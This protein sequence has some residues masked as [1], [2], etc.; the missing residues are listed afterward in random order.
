MKHPPEAPAFSVVVASACGGEMLEECLSSLTGQCA[1]G[2]IIAATN[3]CEVERER[4]GR[5]F[6]GV[7]LLWD[8]CSADVFRLRSLGIAA[9]RGEWIALTEDHCTAS[10][11]WLASLREAIAEKTLVA[12][13]VLPGDCERWTDRGLFL[14]EYASLL[15]PVCA[16]RL[17]FVSGVNAAYPRPALDRCGDVWRDGFYE[18]E[19]SDRLRSAGY[20]FRVAPGALVHSR[21]TMPLGRALAHFYEGGR[22]YGGYRAARSTA[23]VRAIRLLATPAVPLVLLGRILR[24][25]LG[26]W[27]IQNCGEAD[28]LPSEDPAAAILNSPHPNP[29]RLLP[30]APVMIALLAAWAL[31]EAAGLL[32][33]PRIDERHQVREVRAAD[34]EPGSIPNRSCP[35]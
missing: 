24:N 25:V 11:R 20:E 10:P 4:I 26:R 30:V 18:N 21:L 34:A 3:L 6:P 31:G 9:A 1:G 17:S 32:R 5:L 2:E 23:V 19:V 14:C 12:G 8:G 22:R 27:R 29:A 35:G 16:E 7:R 15:P 28:V 13:P 33:G